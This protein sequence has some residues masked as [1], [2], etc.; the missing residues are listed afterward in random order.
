MADQVPVPSL[1]CSAP[2]ESG[3]CG[4]P[5]VAGA[6]LPLCDC[7][8]AV[9]ADWAVATG[10]ADDLLPSP[11]VVCGSAIGTR[12]ASGW[13]CAVCEWPAGEIP[14]S[15]LPPPRVDV[16]Y[17]IRFDHRIKIGTSANPRQRLGTLWH[18]ELLAFERGDRHVERRRHEQF[19]EF[20]LGRSE[21]F[22]INDALTDHIAQLSA[23]VDDPWLLY[24]RWRSEAIRR[25]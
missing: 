16:V 15:D 12:F 25:R 4:R 19:G 13:V 17:Y 2:S 20:R 7:H 3:L 14:D 11:C 23:G 6:P 5:V 8:F 10:I 9:A 24:A 18:H 22:D 21:W 1:S